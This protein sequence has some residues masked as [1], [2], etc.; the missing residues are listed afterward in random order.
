MSD[1][2]QAKKPVRVWDLPTR[3]FHWTL[4]V[5]VIGSWVTGENE[6][7][8]L[9]LIFG[10]CILTVILFRI[11]WGFVGGEHARFADFVRPPAEV[12]RYLA[13]LLKRKDTGSRGHNPLGGLGVIAL[14]GLTGATATL[15]L[16][17]NDDILFDGPLAHLVDYDTGKWMTDLHHE[18]F[19]VLFVFII[20]HLCAIAFYAVVLMKDLITPMVSGNKLMEGD[21]PPAK[22]GSVILAAAVLAVSAGVVWGGLSLV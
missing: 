19:D 14:L 20:L 10:K 16:F 5:L 13:G 7:H 4:V 18:A 9:H 2:T 15:G 3:L 11:L 6:L 17:S 1:E 8:D 12:L 22:G 21:E